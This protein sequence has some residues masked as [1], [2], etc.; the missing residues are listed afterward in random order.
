MK[1]TDRRKIWLEVRAMIDEFERRVNVVFH[2]AD[3]IG[4]PTSSMAGAQSNEISDRTSRT[5]ISL[6]AGYSDDPAV[7]AARKIESQM[8]RLEKLLLEMVLTIDSVEPQRP[9]PA[10]LQTVCMEVGCGVTKLQEPLIKGY[11]RKHYQKDRRAAGKR[12]P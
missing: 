4:Y 6:A 1:N 8:V 2:Y 12:A 9:I 7:F 11:C 10:H 3:Q 5:A